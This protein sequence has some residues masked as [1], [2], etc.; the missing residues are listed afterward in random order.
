M[1][2]L[3][4]LLSVT[5]AGLLACEAV[6]DTI[7]DLAPAG[8][9]SSPSAPAAPITSGSGRV[10]ITGSSTVSEGEKVTLTANVANPTGSLDYEWAL[11]G[12]GSLMSR[13]A[14]ENQVTVV[15]SRQGTLSVTFSVKEDGVEIGSASFTLK[16]IH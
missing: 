15:G 1:I 14:N 8:D 4:L 5:L 2:R 10:T 6:E 9:S 11:T 7:R 13:K 16:V 3:S 12:R